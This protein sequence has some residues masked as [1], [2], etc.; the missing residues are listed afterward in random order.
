MKTVTKEV[1]YC[2][3]CG[4]HLLLKHAMV[5]HENVC[6]RNH[7]NMPACVR[8]GECIHLDVNNPFRCILFG[9]SMYYPN[10]RKKGLIDKYPE[11]FEEK[12]EAPINCIHYQN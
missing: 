11:S 6:S 4:K 8:D 5:K 2:E 12:I 10:A 9:K 7:E 1:Y 3:Y